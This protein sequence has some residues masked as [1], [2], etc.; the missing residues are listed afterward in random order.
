MSKKFIIF[1]TLWLVAVA[2]LN[3]LAWTLDIDR[4]KL[5]IINY[6]I[7][8]VTWLLQLIISIFK[9]RKEEDFSSLKFLIYQV[10]LLVILSLLAVYYKFDWKALLVLALLY[11]SIVSGSKG[12]NA[13]LIAWMVIFVATVVIYRVIPN[14]EGDVFDVGYTVM[15]IALVIQLI[16]S[17]FALLNKE[18]DV[19]IPTFIISVIGLVVLAAFDLA[20]IEYLYNP[21]FRYFIMTHAYLRI[22]IFRIA[23]LGSW[24]FAVVNV[25]VLALQ[26]LVTLAVNIGQKKNVERDRHFVEKTETMSSLANKVKKMADSTGNE[27]IGRLYEALRLADKASKNSEIENRIAEEVA[28]LKTVDSNEMKEEVDLIISLLNER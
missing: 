3:T 16:I 10:V 9:R 11:L 12:Y 22:F 2:T 18:R 6:V 20:M 5:F 19:A 1:L 13:Y 8:N 21:A 4:D 24:G 15:I 23:D 17:Y 28:R 7:L 14:E 26:Y 27:D 25:V